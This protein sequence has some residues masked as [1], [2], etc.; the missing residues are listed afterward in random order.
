MCLNSKLV[1]QFIMS[2]KII[3]KGASEGGKRAY[4]HKAKTLYSMTVSADLGQNFSQLSNNKET[5]AVFC[6]NCLGSRAQG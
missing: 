6:K 2:D 3:R 5:H 1:S 4:C